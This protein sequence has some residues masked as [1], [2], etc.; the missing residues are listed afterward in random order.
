M[1]FHDDEKLK[2]FGLKKKKKKK[3]NSGIYVQHWPAQQTWVLFYAFF[4]VQV[5]LLLCTLRR[6]I[7]ERSCS[8]RTSL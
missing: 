1:N 7:E 4:I 2:G 3:F 6:H 5:Q 8:L